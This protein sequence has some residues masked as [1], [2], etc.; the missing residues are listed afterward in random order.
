MSAVRVPVSV[1]LPVP[2]PA[3]VTPPEAVALSA[4]LATLS[5]MLRAPPPASTSATESPV[6]ASGVSSLTVKAAGRVLTGASLTGARVMVLVSRSVSGP[7]APV[8]PPSLVSI[9]SVTGP[10]ALAAGVKT[11]AAAEAR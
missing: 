11:G 1:R 6:S 8:L 10:L 5:V 7:P 3:T 2:E 9:V 4:P